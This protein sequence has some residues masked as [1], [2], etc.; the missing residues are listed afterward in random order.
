MFSCESNSCPTCPHFNDRKLELIIDEALAGKTRDNMPVIYLSGPMTGYPDFNFPRFN[1]LARKLRFLGFPV[2]NPADFGGDPKHS[3]EHCLARD[4]TLLPHA[5]VILLL[6][7]WDQ[8]N[9][10]GLEFDTAIGLGKPAVTE[11]CFIDRVVSRFFAVDEL[12]DMLLLD[13]W[14][15]DHVVIRVDDRDAAIIPREHAQDLQAI[16]DA[17][18]SLF[19]EEVDFDAED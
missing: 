13:T 3:W 5:D 18:M 8:S 14:R 17:M 1:E 10:A 7:G 2:L 16:R 4:L 19:G 12:S 6:E 11:D 9:G 15:Q